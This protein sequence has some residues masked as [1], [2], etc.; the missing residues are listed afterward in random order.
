MELETM[1]GL[2]ESTWVNVRGADKLRLDKLSKKYNLQRT[3]IVSY[4]LELAEVH[5][6]FDAYDNL[7]RIH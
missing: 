7:R 3:R 6:I 4:L 5:R 1:E 2:K